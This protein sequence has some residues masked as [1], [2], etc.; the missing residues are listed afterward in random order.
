MP[1]RGCSGASLLAAKQLNGKELSYN[2]LLDLD[3]ALAIVRPFARAGGVGHQ[4]Q[5]SVR[6]GDGG[7]AGRS[8]DARRSTAIRRV[9]SAACWHSIA[10]S[11]RRR[12]RCSPRRACSSKRS[13][14]PTSTPTA[15][16]N[17]DDQAQVEGQRAADG[18]RA[19]RRACRADRLPAHRRRHARAGSRR[20]AR[21][22][23]RMEGRHASC[24]PP[25][26]CSPTCAS[27]GR[28][29]GT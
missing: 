15:L 16:R 22:R 13:S 2:N 28:S 25:I 5:Q 11:M 1:R 19:A 24:S 17:P 29:C 26:D 12:P 4:A 20:A 14:L 27:A 8:R 3:S 23:E 10:P 6:R 9:P 7:H 21:S 18:G